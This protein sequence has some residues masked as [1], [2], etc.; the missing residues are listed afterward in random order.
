MTTKRNYTTPRCVID[1]FCVRRMIAASTS[2][3]IDPDERVEG[4][5]DYLTNRRHPIWDT[6]ES[7]KPW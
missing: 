6:E 2:I 3:E 4:E 1:S 5:D 7:R